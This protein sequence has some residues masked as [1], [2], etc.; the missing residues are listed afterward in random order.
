MANQDFAAVLFGDCSGSWQPGP[1]G[2][3]AGALQPITD[4][5]RLGRLRPIPRSN[6]VRLPIYVNAERP[7]RAFELQLRYDQRALRP[8][9]IRP[10]AGAALALA[11]SNLNDRGSVQFALASPVPIANGAIAVIDFETAGHRASD[12]AQV[13]QAVIDA[14]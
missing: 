11:A 3:V 4:R 2:T 8:V 6:H 10:A 13:L 1:T 12:A 5:V 7:F 9:Q 14:Q